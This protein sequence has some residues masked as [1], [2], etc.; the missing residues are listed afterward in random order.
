MAII[1]NTNGGNNSGWLFSAPGASVDGTNAGASI[2]DLSLAAPTGSGA[3]HGSG[4]GAMA[5][6]AL[7]PT[8]GFAT[9]IQNPT[10]YGLIAPIATEPPLSDIPAST[11]DASAFQSSAL[12]NIVATAAAGYAVVLRQI[13][14]VDA[15]NNI[16][17]AFNAPPI[18]VVV[19]PGADQ[20]QETPKYYS[21]DAGAA[22]RALRRQQLEEDEVI[23]ALIQQFVLET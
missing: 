12:A 10:A 8:T 18:P 21:V 22:Q 19:E 15:G 16:G 20:A 9:A 11:G 6:I 17:W 13:G 7:T 4:S 1:G 14:N 23:L 5:A 3:G 2:A